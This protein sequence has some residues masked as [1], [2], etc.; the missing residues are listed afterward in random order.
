MGPSAA[1]RFQKQ[2]EETCTGCPSTNEMGIRLIGVKTYLS[3]NYPRPG[4]YS[5]NYSCC[6][7]SVL[8]VILWLKSVPAASSCFVEKKDR[9]RAHID[10]M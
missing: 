5:N 10:V 2:A 6:N 7:E 9:P 1:L 4:V 8:I 3:M